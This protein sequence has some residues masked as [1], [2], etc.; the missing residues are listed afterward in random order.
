MYVNVYAMARI[1]SY[2]AIK[3]TLKSALKVPRKIESRTL[4][5]QKNYIIC[6]N[7]SPLKFMKKAFYFILKAL[8]ILKIFKFLS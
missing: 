6:F 8:F 3:V 7:E 4:T 2:N 1:G 5:F